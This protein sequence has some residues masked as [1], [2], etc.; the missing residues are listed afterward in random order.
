M[1]TDSK[2]GDSSIHCLFLGS[3]LQQPG[4]HQSTRA[5]FYTDPHLGSVLPRTLAVTSHNLLTF[6]ARELAAI[7]DT[8]RQRG[9]FFPFKYMFYHVQTLSVMFWH[10]HLFLAYSSQ[11]W[12]A[13]TWVCISEAVH[14]QG[15]FLLE[16][17]AFSSLTV[18][19]ANSTALKNLGWR[20]Y[21]L[22]NA[23][24]CFFCINDILKAEINFL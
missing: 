8:C 2:K 15:C 7:L 17:M 11:F 18:A 23:I 24:H 16:P 6:S 1:L 14:F 21:F 4:Q 10:F 20:I 13:W 12:N 3:S 5:L 9:G 19:Y 22:N